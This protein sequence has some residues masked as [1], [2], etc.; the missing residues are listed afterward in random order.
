MD[1]P[2]KKLLEQVPDVILVKHYFNKTNFF[3]QNFT[4]IRTGVLC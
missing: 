2:P 1:K 3:G 4:I